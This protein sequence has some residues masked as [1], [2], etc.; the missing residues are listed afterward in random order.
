[1]SSRTAVAQLA[2]PGIDVVRAVYGSDRSTAERIA[3]LVDIAGAAATLA[4]TLAKFQHVDPQVVG[5]LVASRQ[6]VA[7]VLGRGRWLPTMTRYVTIP[8]RVPA[9]PLASAPLVS[10]SAKGKSQRRSGRKENGRQIP[11]F[12]ADRT[13]RAVRR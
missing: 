3:A 1:M 11:L 4:R 8:P 7:P 12:V 6:D 9:V 10:R 5:A 2:A 13:R